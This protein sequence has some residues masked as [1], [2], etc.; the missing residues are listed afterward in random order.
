MKAV[1]FAAG[2]GTRLKPLT[3]T[4]PK[5][6][7]PLAGKPLLQ[8][9]VEKLRDAGITDIIV[10]VHHFPD[11][12]IDTIRANQAWGCN[13]M[14]SDER[15]QLLDTGGGLKKMYH[16]QLIKPDEPVLACNVDILS[17]I[18]IQALIAQYE[19]TGISQLVVSDRQTQRYLLFDEQNYL[20]GWTNI[21]TGEIKPSSLQG[22]EGGR[23]RHLA[24]SG[25]QVLSPDALARL[26][27]R[28]ED[29]FS[30]IS[31]YL[32]IMQEIPLQ[33]Y[34]PSDYRMMDVGKIDQIS[35]AEAFAESLQ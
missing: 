32:D 9:Q 3:D 33:A 24:F 26:A 13:I 19:K 20:C 31:S 15:N 12:I 5:A 28:E 11:M 30:L 18:D 34:I 23:L 29:K 21:A 27:Q 4:M 17:N 1:I 8:W 7:V 35:E 14:V 22:G 2:L 10:N 16:A 6:L 25:M